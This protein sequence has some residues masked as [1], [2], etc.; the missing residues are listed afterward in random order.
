MILH[1]V[2]E[3]NATK[4][5]TKIFFD[6][7]PQQI[8]V[9]CLKGKGKGLDIIEYGKETTVLNE[10]EV[11]DII[12]FSK[13][14][15]VIVH[16]VT[17][18]KERFVLKYISSK[19][20]V[21]WW[22]YGG[23]LYNYFLYRKGYNLYAPQTIPFVLENQ[24]KI[25]NIK[26]W[27]ASH[28]YRPYIDR[29]FMRRV[30][31]IIPC[32]LPDYKLACSYLGRNVD[33]VNVSPRKLKIDLPFAD[34]N[35]ICIGNSASMTNNHLYA[36]DIIKRISIG[37]SKIILPLSY[38]VQSENYKEEVIKRY[39]Q[40]LGN[41]VSFLFDFQNA[42]EYRR[43]FL[44]YKVAIYPCWR[45][46]ALG[47]IFTCLQLGVKIFLSKYNPCLDIFLELG[48][49]I[50]TIEDVSN[51]QD[52]NPLTQSEKEHNRDLYL[53]LRQE[54]ILS[55]PQILKQYFSKFVD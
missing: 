3:H 25:R 45:Q 14:S 48:Y 42:D 36:L 32:D 22:T 8:V 43:S 29:R 1:I 50:Y 39:R 19:I 21:I 26:K 6:T 15:V 27:I 34:G 13:I 23:D 44:N 16:L 40:Q 17:Y 51:E 4:S 53:K 2:G 37:S 38:N 35:D 52:L 31:G 10:H 5:F 20:P 18:Q 55:T 24:P 49:Y 12:D 7:F 28:I 11:L 54:R 41:H 30:H 33:L 47:N 9:V 46:E